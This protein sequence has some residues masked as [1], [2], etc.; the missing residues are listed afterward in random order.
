[1]L[2]LV[3]SIINHADWNTYFKHNII[4]WWYSKFNQFKTNIL[5]YNLHPTELYYNY[6]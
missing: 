1:M 3:F 5:W 6:L 2:L 4:L